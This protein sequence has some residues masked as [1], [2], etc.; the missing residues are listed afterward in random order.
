MHRFGGFGEEGAHRKVALHGCA[1]RPAENGSEGP[2]RRSLAPVK[3][4]GRRFS[5]A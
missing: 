4:P 2:R 3:G 1:A 5:A